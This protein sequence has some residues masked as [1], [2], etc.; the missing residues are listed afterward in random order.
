MGRLISSRLPVRG[1]PFQPWA[2]PHA[3][4]S[5]EGR[6]AWLHS[7]SQRALGRQAHPHPHVRAPCAAARGVTSVQ[8]PA[9][10]LSVPCYR[11]AFRSS[12]VRG[13]IRRGQREDFCYLLLDPCVWSWPLSLLR[14]KAVISGKFTVPRCLSVGSPLRAKEPPLSS[15]PPP[16]CPLLPESPPSS[17]TTLLC[18]DAAGL[19]LVLL[20]GG[21]PPPSRAPPT[22]A[23]GARLRV[24]TPQVTG[25]RCFPGGTYA[26]Y[27]NQ[28]PLSLRTALLFR[29]PGPFLSRHM[30]LLSAG[31]ILSCLFVFLCSEGKLSACPV[32]STRQVLS[33]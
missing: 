26:R 24:L 1:P 22:S 8:L 32:P 3:G 15:P 4:P 7:G 11:I 20:P 9:T 19:G 17:P 21:A 31:V 33:D 6:R 14:P 29:A 2:S 25:D 23:H 28:P 30:V 12:G 5:P 18:A 16:P 27:L 13:P 10:R